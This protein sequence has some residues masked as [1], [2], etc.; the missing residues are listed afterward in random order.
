MGAKK[1]FQFAVIAMILM[2]SVDFS[3]AVKAQFQPE[4]A[5]QVSSTINNP[6]LAIESGPYGGTINDLKIDQ[7]TTSTLYAASNYGVFKSTT[8]GDQWTLTGLTGKAVYALAIDPVNPANVFA[9][10]R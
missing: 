8:N 5:Q 4:A 7:N 2:G 1:I 10:T 3:G 6:P 9:G